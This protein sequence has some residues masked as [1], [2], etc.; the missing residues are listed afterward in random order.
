MHKK[1]PLI[2]PIALLCA[3]ILATSCSPKQTPAVTQPSPLPN[4]APADTPTPAQNPPKITSI[5]PDRTEL[6]RFESLELV[7]AVEA[8]YGNPYDARQVRLDGVFI[9]PDGYQWHV[10]GFWDGEGAWRVRFTP[11]AEGEWRYQITIQDAGGLS[12]SAEGTFDTTPSDLHGWLAVGSWVTPAYS[13][14]YLAFRDGTPFYG[15][16]HGDALNI[17]DDQYFEENGVGLFD[18]MKAAGENYVVWW[19]LYSYSPLKTSYDNYSVADMSMID[20]VVKDAQKEGIFLVFTIWDH[21]ELRAQGHPWGPGRWETNGFKNLGDIASF[22]TSEEAWAWQENFYRYIIARWGYSP[23]IGIWQT[24]SEINGTNSFAQT[25]DWHKKVNDYFIA[26][27]P[28]RHPTTASMSGDTDWPAGFQM[29]DASQV[30]VYALDQD[31]VKSAQIIARWT[32]KMWEAQEKP[33]WVGEFGFQDNRYYPEMFHNSIWA[34]LGAGAAMTPAEWNDRGGWGKMTPEMYA[35]N[36]RLAQFVASIPLVSLNPVPLTI[37][38][39]DAQVR[40]WGVAGQNGGLFWVQDFAMQGQYIDDVR[41]ANTLRQGVVL[42]I[43]GLADGTYAITPYDTWQGTNLASFEVSCTAGQS[44]QMTLPNFK[45]D[46]A[47]KVERK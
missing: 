13:S 21:P 46:M 14:R 35:D 18:I 28:Y 32:Q 39:S 26:N 8:R 34:A 11:S 16:G 9:G 31:A 17:L 45:A 1:L 43:Q 23:A 44:C 2:T 41:A 10:P 38:S 7:V 37:S 24:V 40:A 30:H 15:V 5:Q 12:Q 3:L 42:G 29:M 6:P 22:F 20:L 19:P 33:N 25:D 4:A 47:F 27:D 36:N